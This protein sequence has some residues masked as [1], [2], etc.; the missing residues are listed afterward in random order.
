MNKDNLVCKKKN[1]GSV[2]WRWFGLKRCDMEQKHV[3]CKGCKKEAATK[4]GSTLN[5]L[6]HFEQRHKLEYEE[7][8]R[9]CR[10]PNR[11]IITAC[12]T[13]TKHTA[14]LDYQRQVTSGVT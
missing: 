8:V 4:S 7:C 6:H 2:I 11:E 1:H 3:I 14:S 5:L 12:R 13:E 9:L 10:N